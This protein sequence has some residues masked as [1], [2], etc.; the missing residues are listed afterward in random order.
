MTAQQL[1]ASCQKR[2]IELFVNL[3]GRVS[4]KGPQAALT[5]K[6]LD[7][8]VTYHDAIKP[9]VPD[10]YA[11]LRVQGEAVEAHLTKCW[12]TA[13]LDALH[14][15]QAGIMPSADRLADNYAPNFNGVQ[16]APGAFVWEPNLWLLASL[17]RAQSLK[18]TYGSDWLHKDNNRP[19][20]ERNGHILMADI[21]AV[22]WW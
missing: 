6:L 11:E 5:P 20:D 8:L 17:H 2:G 9:I 7:V 19:V 13:L 1:V 3:N 4:Y 22:V 21:E 18:R 14:A 12:D 10:V 16:L 15:A